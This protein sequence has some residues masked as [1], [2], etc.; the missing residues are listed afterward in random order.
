MKTIIC[1]GDKA[2][3]VGERFEN[4]DRYNVK[5]IDIDIEGDNCYSI[6]K[7]KTPEEYEEHTPVLKQFFKDVTQDVLFIINGD[8]QVISCSLKILEQIKNK[9]ITIIYLQPEL[10]FLSNITNLQNKLA[11]KVLQEYTRSGLFKEMI[12]FDEKNI[13]S[14]LG[15]VPIMNIN[16]VYNDLIFKSIDAFNAIENSQPITGVASI[17]NA[18]SRISTIGFYDIET[19]NEN[20]FFNLNNPDNKSYNFF[21][22]EEK[23]KTDSG[24]YKNIKQKI[25]N[26]TRDS[27]KLSYAVYGTKN[28]KNFCYVKAY[29]KFIQ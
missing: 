7:Q 4:N 3:D 14:I 17:I 5:L 25:K 10:E 13:E 6:D 28:E 22:N 16:D 27:I 18:I 12:I 24:L 15:D 2:C 1:L 29:S 23:L 26:K 8:S 19:D 9:Q 11:F 21:I 20:L